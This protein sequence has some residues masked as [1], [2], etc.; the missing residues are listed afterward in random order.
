MIAEFAASLGLDP[1]V[2]TQLAGIADA[3]EQ[4]G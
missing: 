3:L 1:A 2:A 4:P